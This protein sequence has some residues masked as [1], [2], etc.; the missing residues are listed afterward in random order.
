MSEILI[1]I[2][3]WNR[4]NFIDEVLMKMFIKFGYNMVIN[5]LK[6]FLFISKWKLKSII[7]SI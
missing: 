6:M 7:K 4:I 5:I 3:I 2:R 1:L